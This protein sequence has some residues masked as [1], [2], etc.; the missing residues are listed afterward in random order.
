M[1]GVEAGILG[2]VQAIEEVAAAEPQPLVDSEGLWFEDSEGIV[3]SDGTATKRKFDDMDADTDV[4][5]PP[6]SSGVGLATRGAEIREPPKYTPLLSASS[7]GPV[8]SAQVRVCWCCV[9][10]AG[11]GCGRGA[12]KYQNGRTP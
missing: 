5:G 4:A 2:S 7:T 6:E 1:K 8:L 11:R 3:N 10:Y 12:G 9:L